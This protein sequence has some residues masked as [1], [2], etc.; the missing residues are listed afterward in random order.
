MFKSWRFAIIIAVAGS[1]AGPGA[2]ASEPLLLGEQPG[3][4][5]IILLPAEIPPASDLPLRSEVAPQAVAPISPQNSIKPKFIEKLIAS[6]IHALERIKL[7]GSYPISAGVGSGRGGSA[8]FLSMG[9]ILMCM[10]GDGISQVRWGALQAKVGA[11]AYFKKEFGRGL[12]T[13]VMGPEVRLSLALEGLVPHQVSFVEGGI[14]I[15]AF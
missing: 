7:T 1:V 2:S 9:P 11:G 3:A 15:S 5:Q 6:M 10:G 4:N 8:C 14:G 12:P 13:V